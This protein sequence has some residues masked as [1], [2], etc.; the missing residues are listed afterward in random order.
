MEG[1]ARKGEGDAQRLGQVL[2]KQVQRRRDRRGRH[3][4]RRRA[5]RRG[6]RRLLQLDRGGGAIV[7]VRWGRLSVSSRKNYEPGVATCGS[8]LVLCVC[9]C[10]AKRA[11]GDD[12]S[13]ARSLGRTVCAYWET[14]DFSGRG[15][16]KGT[17]IDYAVTHMPPRLP[18]VFQS[19]SLFRAGPVAACVAGQAPALAWSSF[20]FS[21]SVPCVSL[22]GYVVAGFARAWPRSPLSTSS[23]PVLRCRARQRRGFLTLGLV[24]SHDA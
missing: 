11:F 9:V 1:P 17:G 19:G 2:L 20:F 7:I 18:A 3:K 15:L 8:A 23:P 6:P 10:P 4:F 24:S 16:S 13:P 5:R 21:L 14:R 12:T 22:A